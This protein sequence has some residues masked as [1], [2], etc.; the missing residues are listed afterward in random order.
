VLL[1]VQREEVTVYETGAIKQLSSLHYSPSYQVQATV[2]RHLTYEHS[3]LAVFAIDSRSRRVVW[4]GTLE[5][6]SRGRFAPNLGRTI[7]S[8]LER[9]P[10]AGITSTGSPPP[11]RDPATGRPSEFTGPPLR[12]PADEPS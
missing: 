9:F 2:E 12:S 11:V 3:W 10:S 7:A 6:R 4:K 1:N 5:G 8:L